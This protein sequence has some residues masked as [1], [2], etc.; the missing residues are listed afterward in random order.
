A[1]QML[2]QRLCQT[3][4]SLFFWCHKRIVFDCLFGC[5]RWILAAN[6]AQIERNTKQITFYFVFFSIIRIFVAVLFK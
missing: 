1:L 6:I 4:V 5:F 2:D 3:F